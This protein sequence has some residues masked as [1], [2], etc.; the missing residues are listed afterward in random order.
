MGVENGSE[1]LWAT[2]PCTYPWFSYIHVFMFSEWPVVKARFYWLLLSLAPWV[3][4]L[5]QVLRRAIHT[6]EPVS[7]VYPIRA[8]LGKVR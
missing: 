4:R 5:E 7:T 1:L 3:S 6:R 2:F 8:E